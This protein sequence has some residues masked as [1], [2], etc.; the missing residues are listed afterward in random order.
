M[1]ANARKAV[2]AGTTAGD[3]FAG[4]S[5]V[6]R[7]AR[8]TDYYRRCGGSMGL[9]VFTVDLVNGRRDVLKPGMALLLQTLVDDPVLLT[10]AS[11]VMV[12]EDG[13][14]DLTSP[15]LQLRT[16]G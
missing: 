4:A 1:Y 12:T 9:T 7:A 5:S 14:E 10:C 16:T 2:K 15:L 11:T 6:Y 13:Y 3:I 8:G